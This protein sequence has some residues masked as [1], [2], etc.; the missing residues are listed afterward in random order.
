VKDRPADFLARPC[1]LHADLNP[2]DWRR[3]GRA[4]RRSHVARAPS[5]RPAGSQWIPPPIKRS[6]N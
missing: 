6:P 5:T 2:E 4:D 1:P 3:A